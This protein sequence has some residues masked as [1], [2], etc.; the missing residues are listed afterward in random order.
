MKRVEVLYYKAKEDYDESKYFDS[1]SE[2]SSDSEN[3]DNFETFSALRTDP[4]TIENE[5]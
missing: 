1:E 2:S 3:K 4:I 5:E